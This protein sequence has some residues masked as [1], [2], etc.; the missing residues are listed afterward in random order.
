LKMD[1]VNIFKTGK[2][3]LKKPVMIDRHLVV[4]IQRDPDELRG[5]KN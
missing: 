1:L 3:H 5:F 2:P 4:F